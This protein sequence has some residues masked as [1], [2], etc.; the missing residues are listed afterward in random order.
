MAEARERGPNTRYDSVEDYKSNLEG[1]N[2]DFDISCGDNDEGDHS[3]GH[4]GEDHIVDD[5]GCGTDE[6]GTDNNADVVA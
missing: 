2:F 6:G 1:G 4:K 5:H 3:D